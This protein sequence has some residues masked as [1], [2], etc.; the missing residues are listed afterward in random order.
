MEAQIF[1]KALASAPFFVLPTARSIPR[2]IGFNYCFINLD[3][4]EMFL[5]FPL[6]PD[7]RK[8]SGVDLTPFKK[9]LDIALADVRWP[10]DKKYM[11]YGPETG[12]V[13]HPAQKGLVD[14]TTLPQNLFEVANRPCPIL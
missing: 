2:S 12:W 3:L 4:G 8:V 7:L 9:D 11:L 13:L 10:E 6:H 1:G 5:N 14:I